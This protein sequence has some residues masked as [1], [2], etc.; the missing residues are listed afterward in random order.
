MAARE[1][2]SGRRGIEVEKGKTR[3]RDHVVEGF[4]GKVFI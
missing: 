2:R 3:R 1:M 4:V